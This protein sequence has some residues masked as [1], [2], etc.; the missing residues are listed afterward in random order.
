MSL[1][2]RLQVLIDHERY[3]RLAAESA[4]T[5]ASIGM[6]VRDA[7]DQRYASRWPSPEEA[8]RR[9]LDAEPMP[10]DDWEIIKRELEDD[11]PDPR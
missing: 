9:L 1:S 6:L 11:A 10:V 5:G 8:G 7:I 4:R 2:R 3:E